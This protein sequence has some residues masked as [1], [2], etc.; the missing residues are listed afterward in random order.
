MMKGNKWRLF[1]LN[2]SFIGWGVLCVLTLGVGS[3]F[4]VP[5]VSAASAEFYVELKNK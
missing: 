3:L 1:K 2:L 4:L 5:Y